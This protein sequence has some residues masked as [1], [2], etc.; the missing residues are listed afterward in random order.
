MDRFKVSNISFKVDGYV[1]GGVKEINGRFRLPSEQEA[2][3][4][5]KDELI[6]AL[7]EEIKNVAKL[8]LKQYQNSKKRNF[9]A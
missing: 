5:A 1:F 3:D 2:F 9:R 8:T 7:K 4:I 6:K